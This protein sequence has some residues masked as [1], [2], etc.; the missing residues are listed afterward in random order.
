VKR[1]LKITEHPVIAGV[2][3][4]IIGGIGF[5]QIFDT[6]KQWAKTTFNYLLDSILFVLTYEVAI[7][8]IIILFL[9]VLF[10]LFIIKKIRQEKNAEITTTENENII[11]FTLKQNYKTGLTITDIAR[12]I[13][14]K[15]VMIIE[16]TLENLVNDKHLVDQ[17][18]HWMEGTTFTLSTQGRDYVLANGNIFK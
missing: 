2:L 18:N 14:S 13:G 7:W 6:F 8:E 10:T 12:T 16:K 3:L 15:D 17:Y 11:L 1:L 4:L 5:A 9:V